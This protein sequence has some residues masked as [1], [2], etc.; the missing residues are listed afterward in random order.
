[1]V[2]R[3]EIGIT[4]RQMMRDR[5]RQVFGHLLNEI[6][7]VQFSDSSEE[8][9]MREMVRN[10]P[11]LLIRALAGSDELG[12]FFG[13]GYDAASVFVDLYLNEQ[14]NLK[15]IN[16]YHFEDI[17]EKINWQKEREGKHNFNPDR[18]SSNSAD[19]SQGKE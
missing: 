19:E 13:I 4:T 5:W 18:E 9:F 6:P 2:A 1:S 12:N 15:K 14:M 17:R 16:G 7:L 11:S 8:F 10:H 3:R